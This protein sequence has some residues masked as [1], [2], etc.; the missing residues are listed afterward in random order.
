MKK[1]LSILLVAAMLTCALAACGSDKSGASGSAS[2]DG[3]NVI[4]FGV[5]YELTGDNPVVGES[6]EKGIDLA[7]DEINAAGGI[8]IDGTAYT[9]AA[10]KL[11]N[12]FN[13]ESSAVVAQTFADDKSI[14]AMIGPND[15][16]MCLGC[17]SVVETEGLPTITPWATQVDITTAGDYFFRA[18]FT[19][20]FQGKILAQY[21]YTDENCK[22]AAVL[23]DMSND[24]CVGIANIFKTSFEAAGGK[25]VEFQSYNA[26]E[27]D[28]TSQLTKILA[29]NPEIILLP[30]F[31][32]DVATQASQAVALG[33]T[34][35][36]IGSDTWGD[37]LLLK[38]DTEGNLNG[39]V[40]CGHYAKDMASDKALAFIDAFEKKYDGTLPN[41][42]AALNYD[43]VYLLKTAIE[44]AKSVDR[45]AI[46]D[47]LS[48][49]GTYEGVTGTMNFN[50]SHDP[51]KS[52]VMIKIVD[53]KFT[54]LK[55]LDPQ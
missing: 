5:N 28:F 40:W 10:K 25:V 33:Y 20:D 46:K 19:D 48:N 34:G 11:D 6:A 44:N 12:E 32:S 45:D 21:A 22:T 27:T 18:C 54:Y 23:Y 50:G 29:V 26:N 24:Y 13:A 42:I 49:I 36:F 16:A 14:C 37:E 31:Y 30:N 7:V 55:T 2:G 41:D 1:V 9:L 8:T 17:Q 52:A 15:S 39:S 47:A 38:L 51:V 43:S 3:S 4:T 53:G 35:K